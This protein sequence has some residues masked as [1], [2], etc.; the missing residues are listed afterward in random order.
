MGCSDNISRHIPPAWMKQLDVSQVTRKVLGE[1]GIAI[2][3]SV[4]GVV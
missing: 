1:Q 4:D 3:H 2:H